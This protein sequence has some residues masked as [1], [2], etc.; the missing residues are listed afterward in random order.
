MQPGH[1]ASTDGPAS[2]TD[3][4]GGSV[5]VQGRGREWR[6]HE[7]EDRGEL[8]GRR[9]VPWSSGGFYRV[10]ERERAPGRGEVSRR[11]QSH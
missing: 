4:G 6:E 11:L 7:E 2:S 3:G 8:G 1:C 9:P 5:G 10:R